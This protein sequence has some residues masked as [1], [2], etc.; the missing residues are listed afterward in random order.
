MHGRVSQIVRIG[1]LDAGCYRVGRP[2][3]GAVG[4]MA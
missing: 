2:L 3:D 4:A 1:R